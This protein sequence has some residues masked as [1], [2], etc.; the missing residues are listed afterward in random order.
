MSNQQSEDEYNEGDFNVVLSR[1]D[2]NVKELIEQRED[3]EKRIRSL[4]R[5]RN[6]AAGVGAAIGTALGVHLPHS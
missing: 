6:W 1:I 3:H 4:E 2:T 5:F